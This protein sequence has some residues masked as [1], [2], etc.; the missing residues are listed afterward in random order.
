[1][2]N[3]PFFLSYSLGEPKQNEIGSNVLKIKETQ[4]KKKKAQVPESPLKE[5][6]PLMKHSLWA[7]HETMLFKIYVFILL[8]LCCFV[9]RMQLEIQSD[10]LFSYNIEIYPLLFIGFLNIFAMIYAIILHFVQMPF[11]FASFVSIWH[12]VHLITL[13]IFPITKTLDKNSIASK[14]AEG[15]KQQHFFQCNL[16]LFSMQ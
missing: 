9:N 3:S 8:F 1:M 16:K 10:L 6:L 11:L 12:V 5:V 2:P 4:D 7:I 14:P 13:C 15:E